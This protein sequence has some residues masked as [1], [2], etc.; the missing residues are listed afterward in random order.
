VSDNY[1]TGE[2]INVELD[3]GTWVPTL[4]A[5][6]TAGAVTPAMDL[7]SAASVDN[8]VNRCWT[9][10]PNQVQQIPA[11]SLCTLKAIVKAPDASA[12]EVI[13]GQD[14]AVTSLADL[15]IEPNE[16]VTIEA[17]WGFS[18][19]TQSTTGSKGSPLEANDFADKEGGVRLVH[20]PFAQFATASAAGGITAAYHK[21]I[22]ATFTWGITAEQIAGFGDASCVNNIQGWMEKVEPCKLTLT[23]LYDSDKLGDFDGTNA[24]KYVGIIQPGAAEGDAA[25]ALVLPN[26]HQMEAPEADYYGNNE[27]RVTVSYSGR[28]AGFESATTNV[29]SNQPWYFCFSD[30]SA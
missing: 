20:E 10:T 14:G 18:D 8:A 5:A 11:S 30:K 24:S 7:P 16:K 19:M 28:P 4:I 17:T 25:W 22:S 13:I 3:D 29:Q 27:H 2:F 21:L 23:M 15:S 6:Y 26:A 12:Y 9:V 1:E